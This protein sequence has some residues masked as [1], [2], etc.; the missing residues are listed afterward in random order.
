MLI[1]LM[2]KRL[3]FVFILVMLIGISARAQDI[4]KF[5]SIFIYNFSKFIQWPDEYKTGDFVIGVLGNSPVLK[6]LKAMASN[7]KVGSQNFKIVNFKRPEEIGKCHILYIPTENSGELEDCVG[8]IANDATLI[9]TDKPGL[10]EV[11]SGINFLIV[12]GKPKFELNK[13]ATEKRKL[14]VSSELAK[15][16][17]MI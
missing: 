15:L 5:H 3:I 16:A 6:H 9:I 14:K 2:K 13:M 1:W 11:G 17:I 12:D 8:I 7:K 10:A 4:H